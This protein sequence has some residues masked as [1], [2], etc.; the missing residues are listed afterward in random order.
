M[1]IQIEGLSKDYG[2]KRVLDNISFSVKKGEIH[3]FLG[4]NGAGKTTT[5]RVLLGFLL[6]NG[7][8]A[9]IW[10][11]PVSMNNVAQRRRIGYLPSDIAFPPNMTGN[12]VIDFA[13]QTRGAKSEKKDKLVKALD[14]DLR[15]KVK[16]CSKG[17]KQKIG[18]IQALA[19]DPELLILDEPTTGLDPLMQQVFHDILFEEH[20]QGKTILVSSHILSDVELLC[21]K[22][23]MIRKGEIILTETMDEVNKRRFKKISLSTHEDT[24]A[25]AHVAGISNLVTENGVTSFYYQGDFNVI[26]QMLSPMRINNIDINTMTM[27]DLFMKYYHKEA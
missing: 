17:M 10:N 11:E 21:D 7:G 1:V 19:H 26:L 5:I 2:R 25:L 9:A 8:S 4:P 14:I 12:E 18:I 27:E 24:A 22:I 16:R 3:G 20:R 13:L 6:S 23:T 15:T